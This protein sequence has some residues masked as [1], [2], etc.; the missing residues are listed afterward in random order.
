MLINENLIDMNLEANTKEEV[1]KKLAQ[2]AYKEGRVNDIDRYI[3]AVLKREAEYST[4]VG[5]GVAIPHGKTDAVNEP[6]LGFAKVKGIDWSAPDEKPVDL[7]FIIGVPEAQAG[8]EHLK[9]LAKLSRRLMKDDF[10]Q[11]LRQASSKTDILAAVQ[12]AVA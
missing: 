11:L 6:F 9:I 8:N 7:I 10:R 3:E 4:S 1:I 2:M 5:F 12:E